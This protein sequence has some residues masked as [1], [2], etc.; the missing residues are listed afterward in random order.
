MSPK[1]AK[2]AT[3]SRPSEL[4]YAAGLCLQRMASGREGRD[5]ICRRDTIPH[6]Q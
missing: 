4:A 1:Q 5:G 6:C 2:Q 3:E